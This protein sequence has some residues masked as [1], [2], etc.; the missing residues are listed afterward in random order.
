VKREGA[1]RTIVAAGAWGV[2]LSACSIFTDLGALSEGSAPASTEDAAADQQHSE[3]GG[4]LDAP[5]GSDAAAVEDADSS[6]T[7]AGVDGDAAG[8]CPPATDPSLQ[9]WYRFDD[10][11]GT[12]V[13]DCSG[14]GRHGA[15]LAGKWTAGRNGTGA[16]EFNGTSACVDLPPGLPMTQEF[17]LAAWV[18]VASFDDATVSRHI[19]GKTNDDKYGWRLGTDEPQIFEM[20]LGTGSNYKEIKSPTGQPFSTWIH[21]TAVF[22]ANMRSEIYINGAL[23]VSASPTS[24]LAS[25]GSRPHIGCSLNGNYFSGL[26]DEL[27][28]YDRALSAPE[29]ADLAK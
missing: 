5:V 7:D 14:K 19:V 9:G 3:G 21:V 17:T 18:N 20:K 24:V 4:P 26:I 29:I 23:K 1:K 15:Q 12:K 6:V 10:G 13:T 2:A 25:D 16:L 27:W 22:V 11:A 28:I 8:P